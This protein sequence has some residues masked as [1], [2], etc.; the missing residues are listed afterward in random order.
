MLSSGKDK[1]DLIFASSLCLGWLHRSKV[2]FL[3]CV[4]FLT[5]CVFSGFRIDAYLKKQQEKLRYPLQA[6]STLKARGVK[7][8]SVLDV[9]A[10]QGA[11]SAELKEFALPHASF[12]LIEGNKAWEPTLRKSGFP[13]RMALVGD[14]EK[15]VTF[16]ILTDTGPPSG[17]NS[18][19]RE[20][21]RWGSSYRNVTEHMLTI[22]IVA[23]QNQLRNI[24]MIKMDIQ[25][26]ELM[27][28][29]GAKETLKTVKVIYLEINTVPLYPEAPQI[30][31][32]LPFMKDLGFT[33][34]DVSDV[35]RQGGMTVAFD[36]LFVKDSVGEV[37]NY[38]PWK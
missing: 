37:W 22:D 27:A 3:S 30:M 8:D 12:F 34:F 6:L 32:V 5:I 21:S 16:Y 17:G 35:L 13:Y 4:M 29:K 15:D 26:A 9:G 33:L 36:G 28:L 23:K 19:F 31:D 25:G 20:T 1:S 10:N 14:E 38:P 2:L 18:V 7:I 11:W 24:D